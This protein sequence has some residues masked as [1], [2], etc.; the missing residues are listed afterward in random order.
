[1]V[2]DIMDQAIL[3]G[4]DCVVTACAMCQLNLELRCRAHKRLPVFSVVELLAYGLGAPDW[5]AGF[6]KH[7]ID[8]LPLFREKHFGD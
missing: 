1:M 2:D 3:A 8:P 6:K 4:A 5:L 7:L